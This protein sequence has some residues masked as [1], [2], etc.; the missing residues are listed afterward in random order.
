MELELNTIHIALFLIFLTIFLFCT[1]DLYPPMVLIVLGFMIGIFAL[2]ITFTIYVKEN[3]E[4][5]KKR[6]TENES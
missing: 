3:K 6:L 4:K 2:L 5:T 1:I